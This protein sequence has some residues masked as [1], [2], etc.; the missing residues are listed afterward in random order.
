MDRAHD[1]GGA[2]MTDSKHGD[3]RDENGHKE[4]YDHSNTKDV[5]DPRGGRHRKEDRGEKED[6]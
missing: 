4:G 6:K 5:N 3:N 1:D 2:A